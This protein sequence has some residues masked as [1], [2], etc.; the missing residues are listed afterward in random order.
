M[1][2]QICG[3]L[4]EYF[5]M[6]LCITNWKMLYM[7]NMGDFKVVFMQSLGHIS[8][9]FACLLLISS[10]KSLLEEKSSSRC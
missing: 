7:K 1:G 10:A 9:K 5:I 6:E 8:M 3:S 4:A 2:L